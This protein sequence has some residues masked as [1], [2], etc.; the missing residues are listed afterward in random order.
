MAS[1]WESEGTGFEPWR[2]LA[3]FD[4]RVAKKI[5]QKYSQPNGVPLK[6]NLARH[7]LRKKRNIKKNCCVTLSLGFSF[8][9]V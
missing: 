6:I 4:R 2:L 8:L 5:Q 7:V 1:S 9:E 3:T